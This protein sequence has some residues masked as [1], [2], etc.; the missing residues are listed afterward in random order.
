MTDD[1]GRKKHNSYFRGVGFLRNQ[2]CVNDHT[3]HDQLHRGGS[4]DEKLECRWHTP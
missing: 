4:I 3:M 1:L 2:K